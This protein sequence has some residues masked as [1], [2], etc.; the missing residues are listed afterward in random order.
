MILKTIFFKILISRKTT[1]SADAGKPAHELYRQRKR[2]TRW[3]LLEGG[4]WALGAA[5]QIRHVGEN[6]QS[7]NYICNSSY[8]LITTKDHFRAFSPIG[9]TTPHRHHGT[10]AEGEECKF[11]KVMGPADRQGQRIK[12]SPLLRSENRVEDRDNSLLDGA[13]TVA[14]GSDELSGGI[15][16][17]NQKMAATERGR[18]AEAA[19]AACSRAI[20][21]LASSAG[22]ADAD[23]RDGST[24]RAAAAAGARARVAWTQGHRGRIHNAATVSPQGAGMAAAPC[25]GPAGRPT[26]RTGDACGLRQM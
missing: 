18:L 13:A 23:F 3:T 4:K 6:T 22:A 24:E 5:H 26:A 7:S 11:A 9:E 16:A 21:G 17:G 1:P 19:S 10:T 25:D 14:S 20:S 12:L 8:L 15:G 2:E